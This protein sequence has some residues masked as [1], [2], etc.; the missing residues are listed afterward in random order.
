MVAATPIGTKVA[1]TIIR[2]GALEELTVV[3][4]ERPEEG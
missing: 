4:N 3:V 1:V 2:G